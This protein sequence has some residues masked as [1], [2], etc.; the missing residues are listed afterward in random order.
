MI[1]QS[2]SR[3]SVL[4]R[5]F[6]FDRILSKASPAFLHA[7]AGV[8]HAAIFQNLL[9]LAVFAECSVDGDEG[10]IDVRGQLE[11]FIANIDLGDFRA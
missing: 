7:F 1:S 9:D 6:S 2:R 10:E 3:N 4:P 5:I 8:G 11:I